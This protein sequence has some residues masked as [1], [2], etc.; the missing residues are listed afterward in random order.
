MQRHVWR[1]VGVLT[2]L[3]SNSLLAA[4]GRTDWGAVPE[5]ERAAAYAPRNA[6]SSVSTVRQGLSTADP[7]GGRGFD[8]DSDTEALRGTHRIVIPLLDARGRTGPTRLALHYQAR[9]WFGS[10]EADM[11]ILDGDV[12]NA[13]GWSLGIPK[14][15]GGVLIEA[16]GSR[17]PARRTTAVGDSI[18]DVD[19]SYVTTDGS[20]ISYRIRLGRASHG[21][22]PTSAIGEIRYPDGSITQLQGEAGYNPA[23][24]TSVLYSRLYARAVIDAAGNATTYEYFHWGAPRLAARPSRIVD[25]LGREIRFH[26]DPLWGLTAITATGDGGQPRTLARLTYR[27]VPAYSYVHPTDPAGD[28]VWFSFAVESIY[29]PATRS[30]YWFGDADSYTRYAMLRK[31][32]EQ[33]QMGHTSTGLTDMGTLTQGT[34][35]RTRTYDLPVTA[36]ATGDRTAFPRYTTLTETIA[37]VAAPLVTSFAVSERPTGSFIDARL[38]DETRRVTIRDAR[39]LP[40]SREVN[41]AN[42][43]LVSYDQ[44]EWTPPPA[45]PRLLQLTETDPL[46]RKRR[47]EYAFNP[48]GQLQDVKVRD[49]VDPAQLANAP[50]LRW[51]RYTYVTDAGY[52]SRGMTGLVRR[53]ETY[54]GSSL[55]PEERT[56]F[57]YDGAALVTTPGIGRNVFAT[58]GF[59]PDAAALFGTGAATQPGLISKI[60]RWVEPSVQ[61]NGTVIAAESR[62]TR[63]GALSDVSVDGRPLYSLLYSSA[64]AFAF[65]DRITAGQRITPRVV[66]YAT[67]NLTW[68]LPVGE[69]AVLR[70][71]SKGVTR[72][73][74]DEAQRLWKVG[75]SRGETRTR[76]YEADARSFTDVFTRGAATLRTVRTEFDGRSL[77]TRIVTTVTGEPA[78]E[79]LFEYDARGRLL[80][81]VGS[82]LPGTPEQWSTLA[83]DPAG[84]V[85]LV[86]HPDGTAQ[87][88]DFARAGAPAQLMGSG[89]ARR[90]TDSMERSRYVVTDALNRVVQVLE[91]PATGTAWVSTNYTYDARSNLL[92]VSTDANRS[93]GAVATRRF[94]YDGLSRLT[95]R[96]LIERAPALNAGGAL[97]T[98]G[99][100]SDVYAY[101]GQSKLA[102]HVDPRGVVVTYDYAGD[103]LRRLRAVRVTDPPATAN[104]EPIVPTPATQF[105]Y[106]RSGDPFRL[107]HVNVTGVLSERYRYDSISKLD[108]I[109][110][111][112]NGL[113]ATPV[114]QGV[115]RNGL[116][117]VE[118]FTV[119]LLGQ[120]AQA[121]GFG[122]DAAGR[123][124]KA[125]IT[126]LF[127][128]FA[129]TAQIGRL[130]TLDGLSFEA[131]TWRAEERFGL[132]PSGSRFAT[133]LL[134]VQ[135]AP[136]LD[137]T[138]FY[139]TAALETALG[140]TGFVALASS[141]QLLG[142]GD[143][144]GLTISTIG[145]DAVG[146][147]TRV[148]NGSKGT[149][150][151]FGLTGLDYA[152]DAA[153][154]RINSKAVRYLPRPVP[155]PTDPTAAVEPAT[156]DLGPE[157]ADGQTALAVNP[158][159]NRI[160]S[161]GFAYDAAGNLTR[162]PRK[163]GSALK[164][165]YD[166]LGRLRG[167][168]R[169]GTTSTE[170]YSYG[171]A[172]QLALTRGDSGAATYTVWNGATGATRFAQAGA[173]S[174][175]AFASTAVVLAGRKVARITGAGAARRLEF[176]HSTPGGMVS[177]TPPGATAAGR[178]TAPFGSQP[179]PS[180]AVDQFHSYER[181]KFGLDYAINRYYDPE[182]GRFVQPDPLGEG[183]YRLQDP[184]SLNLYAFLR[185]DPLNRRDP[186]GLCDAGGVASATPDGWI[187]CAY[188][189]PKA[190]YETVVHANSGDSQ[191][192]LNQW[193]PS[194]A[195]FSGWAPWQSTNTK[196]SDQD[197]QDAM[198]NALLKKLREMREKREKQERCAAANAQFAAAAT[199]YA[200]VSANVAMHNLTVEAL[201]YSML[202][203]GA[204]SA[205]NYYEQREDFSPP[206]LGFAVFG[207]GAAAMSIKRQYEAARINQALLQADQKAA[208]ESMKN[209]AAARDAACR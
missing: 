108:E 145:Y 94:H 5:S 129:V 11:S 207:R 22:D 176:L 27:A 39:G 147:M 167:V 186:L 191:A 7:S 151:I 181:S 135:G 161:P 34:T 120:P 88:T 74:Y 111:T 65:P 199:A 122:Y 172:N 41:A 32:V 130:G 198:D 55:L 87:S 185:N 189:Y 127:G 165:R 63:A 89:T 3:V 19:V 38:P 126:D 45:T 6:R 117:Q 40:L 152:Y 44:Y 1:L 103:P 182:T 162:L 205:E 61:N 192:I 59:L 180:A 121:L 29:F 23:F 75:V 131:G 95:H 9:I 113:S 8:N 188:L 118:L 168:E 178:G 81:M 128:S 51:T 137:Y 169:E 209:T 134:T 60:S 52:V 200:R 203:V 97:S 76:T 42:G 84:R 64:T 187:E 47:T 20:N 80:R 138:Y 48:T 166:G 86:A 104:S 197:V 140:R 10:S 46:G 91:P 70:A 79:A 105:F 98:Q 28:R 142:V 116:G 2:S 73:S 114:R 25:P 4:P 69:L 171:I 179:T 159:T 37:G 102:R 62:Y 96:Y 72:F 100:W 125:F 53:I 31:V 184:Q 58:P 85:T 54:D 24:R 17:R 170:E 18:E 148:D 83:Y 101:D 206:Q 33:S 194:N 133:Q 26:Y 173:A 110:T 21:T 143:N 92:S 78:V 208:V 68:N 201:Q 195:W 164:L 93:G 112:F 156:R 13:P 107:E 139:D 123:R 193:V 30:G 124:K 15:L 16:D 154:N 12:T 136:V 57:E 157:A 160:T 106:M 204:D 66:T 35:T 174:P 202:E 109:V 141:N 56:D 14:V 43:T 190:V 119:G 115:T 77:P 82:H 50:L 155:L 196:A 67:S 49:W 175:L 71:P 146:R 163:D 144:R 153:G 99:L 132:D 158:L 149:A 90:E 150:R 36:P 183:T 177:T